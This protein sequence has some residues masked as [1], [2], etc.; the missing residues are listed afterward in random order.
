M[1]GGIFNNPF[2]IWGRYKIQNLSDNLFPI[3]SYADGWRPC[4]EIPGKFTTRN[5]SLEMSFRQIANGNK[6]R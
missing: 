5:P 3:P 2:I 6:I 1:N 4:G